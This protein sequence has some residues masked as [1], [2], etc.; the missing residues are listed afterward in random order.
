MLKELML[1]AEVKLLK[2]N[3]AGCWHCV[4]AMMHGLLAL[5]GP[6]L[7]PCIGPVSVSRT[8]EAVPVSAN[9]AAVAAKPIHAKRNLPIMIHS[10]GQLRIIDT[11]R[12]I[13]RVN[14]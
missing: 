12:R 9:I 7:F 4:A 8:A 5:C 13:A 11:C 2:P 6:R 3:P 10:L 14:R 1:P